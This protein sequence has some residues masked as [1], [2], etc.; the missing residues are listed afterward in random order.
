[1]RFRVIDRTI[2]SVVLRDE[3][4]VYTGLFR[5]K[6]FDW[7]R[8]ITSKSTGAGGVISTVKL[9]NV[10][11][12]RG[13]CSDF[14]GRSRMLQLPLLTTACNNRSD[15][16]YGVDAQ[17]LIYLTSNHVHLLEREPTYNN[18]LLPTPSS[19]QFGMRT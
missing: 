9:G 2:S 15:L 13:C 10:T 6:K 7:Q 11:K 8:S 4:S 19:L 18:V 3:R 17:A 1:M 5:K 16:M 14:R 12:K